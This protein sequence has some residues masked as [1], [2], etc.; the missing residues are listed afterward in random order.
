[1]TQT[2]PKQSLS[3]ILATGKFK[4]GVEQIELPRGSEG[5]VDRPKLLELIGQSLGLGRVQKITIEADKPVQIERLVPMEA[6]VPTKSARALLDAARNADMQELTVKKGTDN[7]RSFFNAYTIIN[8]QGLKPIAVIVNSIADFKIWLG[9]PKAVL[10]TKFYGVELLEDPEMPSFAALVAAAT[11][12]DP[13]S[14]VYS[15]RV[16]LD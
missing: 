9:I 4:V 13:N 3:T 10:V 16:P 8:N 15:L 12:D 14:V 6:N 7:L 2:P 5:R 1:M 11:D